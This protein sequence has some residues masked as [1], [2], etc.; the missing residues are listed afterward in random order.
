QFPPTPFHLL[1]HFPHT[2]RSLNPNSSFSFLLLLQFHTDILKMNSM[3]SYAFSV[4]GFVFSALL[5][6]SQAQT[7]A[8]S[9][10]PEGP[11]S[12]GSAIDQGIAYVLLLV[13]LA[14]TYLV[15]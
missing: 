3:R 11:I 1:N 12:D 15:H 4:I 6:L 9:P 10:A 13:A 5:L 8:P 14:I 2:A 7:L